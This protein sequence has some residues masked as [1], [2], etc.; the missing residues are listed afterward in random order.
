MKKYYKLTDQ[1]MQTH[2]GFQ[3]VLGEWQEAKGDESQD[4]CSDGWLHCYSS[5]LLAV[6]HNPIHANIQ[7][8][9]LF[10]IEV[11]GATKDDNGIKQGFR[12]MRLIKEMP[13]PEITTE[14]RVKY[15]I[16]CA[17]DIYEDED[18][19]KWADNWL[20]GRSRSVGA[21]EAA[22]RATEAAARAAAEAAVWAAWTTEA[23][24]WTAR[25]AAGQQGQ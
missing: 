2:N 20:S 18:F 1:K 17:K 22:A 10:E 9:R 11:S 15:A 5:P 23:A 14:Q 19:N 24:A 13:K 16:L 25:A 12:K 21:A 7:N 8:P 4:L 3:W 6:L